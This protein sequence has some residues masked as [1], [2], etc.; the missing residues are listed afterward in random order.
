MNVT[1][2]AVQ[3]FT[4]LEAYLVETRQ[5]HPLAARQARVLAELCADTAVTAA[6]RALLLFNLAA[7]ARGVP[8]ATREYLLRPLAPE[9]RSRAVDAWREE[10]GGAVPAWG[11]VLDDPATAGAIAAAIDAAFRD[12]AGFAP[13][14]GAPA[15]DP[16]DEEARPPLL[17]VTG[18]MMGFSRNWQALALLEATLRRRLADGTDAP[19]SAAAVNRALAAVFGGAAGLPAGRAFHY[20]QA[21]AAALALRTRFMVLS[22]GPGTGKTSVVIQLLRAIVALE[23][24][25]PDRIALCAPTGRAKARLGEA[26]DEGIAA[27][28]AADP[29][30][31]SFADLPRATLH[32]LLALRPDGSTRYHR[33]NPLPYEV[34][35]V[36]EASM[37][38]LRLFSL[39]VDAASPTCRLILVGDMHQLPPVEAGAVL[40][41]LTVPFGGLAG[42]P[43]L[44]AA[45]G[46][47]IDEALAGLALDGAADGSLVLDTA[48]LA[49]V[50]DLADHV[51]IL[52]KSY[53]STQTILGLAERVNAGDAAG[54]LAV[55]DGDAGGALRLDE[56]PGEG[57]LAAWLQ[58]HLGGAHLAA[59]ADLAGCDPEAPDDAAAL[60]RAFAL[61]EGSRV[62]ALVHGGRRGRERINEL[63]EGLFRRRLDPASAGRFYHGQPVILERNRHDLDL[64]NGDTGMV[65][66]TA[67]GLRALFRRSGRIVTHALELLA[68]L[69]PAYA[70]TVHK[71][72]GSEFDAVL[73]ALPEHDGPLLSRQVMYTGITRARRRVVILGT[74]DLVR[75]AVANRE[76]RPGG[77]VL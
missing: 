26:V 65:V 4:A 35:V 23:G 19:P 61:F 62:L 34:V 64:Y 43:S 56:S 33:G 41:D 2:I 69:E 75:A 25:S 20:R 9:H 74:R 66:R 63:A 67:G 30:A 50:G 72:Q 12:P 31:P 7:L 73:L 11:A 27:V 49:R 45:T 68:D 17:V 18:G 24:L 76:E 29:Q 3:E 14:A 48:G 46:A 71:A 57:P 52:T 44:S 37:V 6:A 51:V 55:I 53:R 16:F 39:L 47:W 42:A 36:D 15:L 5:L 54:A 21:A 60:A 40:G 38:D 1:E 10:T 58:E 77:I 13:L 28:A 59:L 32:G 8:R 22:G 70:V